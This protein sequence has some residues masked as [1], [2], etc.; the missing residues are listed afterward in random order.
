MQN[1]LHIVQVPVFL[2]NR[3]LEYHKEKDGATQAKG[4]K[5]NPNFTALCAPNRFVQHTETKEKY[6]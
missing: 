6:G 3:I 1:H 2:K 4:F 5:I